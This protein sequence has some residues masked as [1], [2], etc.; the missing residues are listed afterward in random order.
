MRSAHQ[1]HHGG[2]SCSGSGRTR[3]QNQELETNRED[4]E[5]APIFNPSE[6]FDHTTHGGGS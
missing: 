2:C 6:D 1:V 5:A 4:Q 3:I